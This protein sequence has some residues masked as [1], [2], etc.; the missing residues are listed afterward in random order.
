VIRDWEAHTLAP[1]ERRVVV[2]LAGALYDPEGAANHAHELGFSV[3]ADDVGRWLGATSRTV[4]ALLLALLA[5]LEV[6]PVRCGHGPRAMSE[7]APQER[8]RYLAT[9]DAKSS[10]ALDVWKSVLGMAHFGGARGAERTRV[11][12]APITRLVRRADSRAP[13]PRVALPPPREVR[14]HGRRAS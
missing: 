11:V 1:R 8:V 3:L 14:S 10:L 12:S 13:D 6:S 9:L 4:R 2:A 7:L 5:A